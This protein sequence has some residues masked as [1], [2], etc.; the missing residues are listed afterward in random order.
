VSFEAKENS[1]S[2]FKNERKTG[3][4]PDYRGD[5]NINGV[6]CK[7]SGWVKQKKDGSKFL[8]LAFTKKEEEA[9]L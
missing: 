3:N 5:C 6:T 1:G 9:G 4:Q 8:S 7:I 2:L